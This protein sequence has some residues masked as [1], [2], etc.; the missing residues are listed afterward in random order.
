MNLLFVFNV[1]WVTWEWMFLFSCAA[2]SVHDDW[3]L[4]RYTC[5][6][7][8]QLCM[9]LR[10]ILSV[11]YYFK[12]NPKLY[13]L[14][15]LWHFSQIHLFFFFLLSMREGKITSYGYKAEF[16]IFYWICFGALAAPTTC[17]LHHFVFSSHSQ[18]INMYIITAAAED[19][20]MRFRISNCQASE[21]RVKFYRKSW[22]M[23]IA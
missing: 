3:G 17:R 18:Q 5:S 14:S 11:W 7:E 20:Y 6:T 9:K 8:Q 2:M 21:F 15:G 10:Q 16:M 4:K 23:S 12:F 22:S 1:K 19:L 13:V